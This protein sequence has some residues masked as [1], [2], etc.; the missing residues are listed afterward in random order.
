MPT[1]TSKPRPIPSRKKHSLAHGG[2]S[3]AVLEGM[4]EG[5]SLK[6]LKE[7]A[8]LTETRRILSGWGEEFPPYERRIRSQNN[9]EARLLIQLAKDSAN[10]KIIAA[11]FAEKDTYY[12]EALVRRGMLV[13][14]A[15]VARRR[16]H[17]RNDRLHHFI[18]ALQ[19]GGSP[20]LVTFRIS[21]NNG[22][23]YLQ[24]YHDLIRVHHPERALEIWAAEA[25][26]K[27]SVLARFIGRSKVLL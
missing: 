13:S 22:K 10:D 20:P 21:K 4:R 17:F 8:N 15:E 26:K 5:W 1:K 16:Y 19:N 11:M 6:Q 14:V 24:Q 3:L 9:Q 18:K 12:R 7:I 27:D 25:A 23:P 2:K